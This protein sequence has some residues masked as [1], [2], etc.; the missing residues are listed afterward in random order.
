[1][2]VHHSFKPVEF[3]EPRNNV[4]VTALERILVEMKHVGV[5]GVD[6]TACGCVLRCTHGLLCA[7]EITKYIRYGRS[8]PLELVHAHWHMLNMHPTS[9]FASHDLDATIDMKLFLQ[10]FNQSN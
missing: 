10:R 3:R 7:H 1:M 2:V 5:V 8:I 6:S 9:S 4:S